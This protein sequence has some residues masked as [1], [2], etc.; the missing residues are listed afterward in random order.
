MTAI[1]L[2]T[3]DSYPAD[4]TAL[5]DRGLG[6]ANELAAPLHEVQP[7]SCFARA[8]SGQV[9]GGAVGRWWGECCELQQLWVEPSQRRQGIARQLIQAFEAHA[10]AQACSVFYL[11]T[12]TFQAPE[13]YRS[14]GYEVAYRHDVY[15]HGIV[16][17]VMVKRVG[18]AAKG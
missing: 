3:H 10:R 1:S 8:D 9:I 11:E 4:E 13:L 5:I 7:I 12:F 16:K 6:E 15:P 17:F 18:A 2:T 14:L